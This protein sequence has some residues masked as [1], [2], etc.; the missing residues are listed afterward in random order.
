MQAP[1]P[2]ASTAV[3]SAVAPTATATPP[4]DAGVDF[5]A[6][7]LGLGDAANVRD[8]VPP[9]DEDD[10]TGADAAAPGD[11]VALLALSGLAFGNP[12]ARDA[13]PPTA[14]APA[15]AASDPLA[16]I[17]AEAR[18]PAPPA[19]GAAL[20]AERGN[21][22]PAASAEP[23]IAGAFLVATP[24]Q[25]AKPLGEGPQALRRVPDASEATVVAASVPRTALQDA[26]REA[27]GA[28]AAEGQ[29]SEALESTAA[30]PDVRA[31][32]GTTAPPTPAIDVGARP[33]ST[34]AAAQAT[35]ATPMGEPGWH[36]EASQT[37]AQLVMHGRER[38]ELRLNPAD[39]GPVDVRIEVR[40]GE[41]TL[42]I[43]APHA[44]TRD[45]LEQALPQLKEQL[46]QQ[47]IAV[48]DA[49]VRDGN[50]D[51]SPWSAPA[52]LPARDAAG[53]EASRPVLVTS[54]P[55]AA[56]RASGVD[57]YA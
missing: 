30:T 1:T 53:G 41:A 26:I 46:A 16:G 29:R 27:V 42:A 19:I 23:D 11:P 51:R 43:V 39:L 8:A 55:R 28:S 49:T 9:L 34:P 22:P 18:Q 37:L 45:A 33:A 21:P 44:T 56:S 48:T 3:A 13:N 24:E 10:A 5:T 35:I 52:P 31:G 17:K 12:P 4:D 32:D 15:V 36:D 54:G 38:A 57:L 50:P 14:D 40:A 7:L 20:P 47:G 6:L 25:P 2:L